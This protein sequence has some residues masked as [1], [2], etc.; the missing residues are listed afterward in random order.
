MR[1][2]DF[3]DS[4]ESATEPSQGVLEASAL[5]VFADDAAF[6]TDKGTAVAQGDIYSRSSDDV[7]RYY[8]GTAWVSLANLSDLTSANISFSPVGTIAASDLQTAVAEVATD[9]AAALSS[10]ESDTTSVH[11]ITDTSDLLLKSTATTKG[12]LFVATASA[13]IARQGIGSDGLFLKADS[14]QS[15]GV[16]WASV[17]GSALSVVSKTTTYIATTSD[18][19]ILADTSGGAWTLTLYAAS[20]NSG[21]VL[22]VIKTTSDTNALTIDGNAS[23]TINGFANIKLNYQ[24]DEVTIVCDGTGWNIVAQLKTPTLTKYTTGSG[25]YNTP[26]GVKYLKIKMVGGG[27]GGSGSGTSAGGGGDGGATTFLTSGGGALLTANPGGGGFAG[28]VSTGGVGGTGGTTSSSSP[29]IVLSSLQGGAGQGGS[30]GAVGTAFAGG[31]G[32]VSPFGGGGS[33]YGATNGVTGTT[34][35]G[36]A[37]TGSG[38]GGAGIFNVNLANGTGGGA[39]GFIEA[40]IPNPSATYEYTIGAGGTA[41]GAGTSGFAG[42]TGGSGYIEVTEYYQ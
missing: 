3:S 24:F 37:N 29:A 12:D 30:I 35:N 16:T 32:A 26:S 14:A 22:R 40:I 4:F 34:A 2:L 42:G 7:I 28:S 5:R 15:T 18:D 39:G 19:V 10:H 6:V 31:Q 17:S 21:K 27:G 11:G 38:G 25:N 1:L 8:N 33:G 13:T 9:A 36:I 20:G 23:E 41:G